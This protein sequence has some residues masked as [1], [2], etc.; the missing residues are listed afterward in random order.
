[1]ESTNLATSHFLLAAHKNLTFLQYPKKPQILQI[2]L[3]AERNITKLRVLD[4]LMFNAQS[5]MK[6]AAC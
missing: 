6:V 2:S 3:V 1:M 4:Q 5:T